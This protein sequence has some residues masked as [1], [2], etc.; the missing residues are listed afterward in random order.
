VIQFPESNIDWRHPNEYKKC[1]Q[2]VTSVF[3]HAKLITSSSTKRTVTAHQPG[4]SL[5]VRV[6]NFTGRIFESGKD[7]EFGR[8]SYFKTSGRNGRQLVIAT[9]Y[10]VCD[11]P[12]AS[13]GDTT[14]CKQQHLILNDQKRLTTH[15][16]GR[17][18]PH[19]R[20]ALLT[21]LS[22]Q[23]RQWRDEGFEVLLSGDLN[24]VIGEVPTKFAAFT[25]AFNL[26]DIYRHQH[27]LDE[28]AT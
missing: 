16:N 26:T 15:A 12:V 17:V 3:S 24:E 6:D 7:K 2:A 11:Q 18:T 25:T 23:M 14:A 22:L 19:P 9:V 13:T 20:A 1:R 28:P 10:Q 21:D 27:G 8:W 4:G 5:T